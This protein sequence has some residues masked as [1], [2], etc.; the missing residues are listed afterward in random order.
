MEKAYKQYC[1]NAELQNS[2]QSQVA[3]SKLVAKAKGSS[4]QQQNEKALAAVQAA[5]D[6]QRNQTS[7]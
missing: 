5:E 4:K 1:D 6:D 3:P 7:G 2:Q